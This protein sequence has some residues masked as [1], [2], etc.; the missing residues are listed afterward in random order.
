MKPDTQPA[1]PRAR[2]AGGERTLPGPLVDSLDTPVAMLV[3]GYGS[4]KTEVAVNLAIGLAHTGRTVQ[5]ADLDLVNPYFR[6]REAR[7]L[8]EQHG[9]RVVVPPGAQEFA[10]LPIVRPEIAGML[11]PPAGSL[12]LFDVGGD[13]VGARALG[14]FRPVLE[15]GRYELWQVINS[16]RPFSDTPDGCAAMGASIEGTSRLKIT[17][18]LVNSHLITETTPE[19]VLE[20]WELGRRVAA[21]RGLPLRAVAVM[22]ELSGAPELAVID[23]PVLTMTRRMLPPWSTPRDEPLPAARPVPIGR[24]TGGHHG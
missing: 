5:V 23:V 20:G 2:A 13:D 12:S 1:A 18:L 11:R 17:G 15:D 21:E 24:P 22:E 14:A 8:M 10:D 19:V 9:I 3:G 16:R 4:G 6:C 7:A